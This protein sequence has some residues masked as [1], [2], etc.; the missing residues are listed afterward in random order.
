MKKHYKKNKDYRYRYSF[1]GFPARLNSEIEPRVKKDFEI[2]WAANDT[3][4]KETIHIT[5]TRDKR[6]EQPAANRPRKSAT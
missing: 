3:E 1:M 2:D 6:E 4:E 5:L